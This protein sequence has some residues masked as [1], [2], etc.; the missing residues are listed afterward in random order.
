MP[1]EG[2]R[3]KLEKSVKAELCH[4]E[5]E[6]NVT[7]INVE[8]L[9]VYGCLNR[10]DVELSDDYLEDCCRGQFEGRGRIRVPMANNEDGGFIESCA[11][12]SG[13]FDVTGYNHDSK[14]FTT[15]II[16]ANYHER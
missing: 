11:E 7:C 6:N 16:L 15:T 4:Y 9:S 12:F 8:E 1:E 3:P 2:K 13:S 5:F 14:Q 10:D